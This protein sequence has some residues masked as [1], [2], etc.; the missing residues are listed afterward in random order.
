LE[1]QVAR[2]VEKEDAL[3]FGMGFAT[4]ST[5][6]PLLVDKGSLVI[7]DSLNH[8]S[9][10]IGCK[11]SGA[12]LQVFKH[13]D[14]KELERLLGRALKNGQNSKNEPHVPW[15][16]ILIIVEGIYSMEGEV[17]R[18]PEIIA[19]KKK[20]KA[21]LYIDEAHSIGSLGPRGRGVCD[22]WKVD[23]KDVDVLM[24]T[25]TKSFSSVGGYIAGSKE[26]ISSL[27]SSSFGMMYGTSM[28]P[29]CVQQILSCID[30]ITGEN[31][32]DEGSLRIRRLRE[33]S[34]YFRKRLKEEGFVMAGDYDSPVIPMMIYSPF[35][36]CG[37]SRQLM[38]RNIAIV[39]VGYPAT[40]ILLGRARFC[41]SSAHTLDQLEKAVCQIS[42]LG[43]EMSIDYM[44]HTNPIQFLRSV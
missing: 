37:L 11:A 9:L 20:Y 26:I 4:N 19:L 14:L 34:I 42:K 41:M 22:Y 32:T 10:V 21:Y 39:V 13:N 16:K 5:N 7:S 44:K 15:K 38:E 24:G 6:L 17:L 8:A 18:L 30:I 1:K 43:K 31:G 28:P 40:P 29:A 27:R 36:F 2:F 23:P 12:T 35:K 3:I 33:N 25:F